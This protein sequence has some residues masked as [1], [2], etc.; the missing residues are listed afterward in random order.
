[1]ID[2]ISPS[3]TGMGL[4]II[5]A[6]SLVN[7]LIDNN[8]N[9]RVWT[10]HPYLFDEIKATVIPLQEGIEPITPDFSEIN[11]GAVWIPHEG[12][13][14]PYICK[15][16]LK[17]SNLKNFEIL[18]DTKLNFATP[19]ALPAYVE[20]SARIL[21]KKFTNIEEKS[22]RNECNSKKIVINL[23][24]AHGT[25]KGLTNFNYVSNILNT[26]AENFPSLDFYFF[27]NA[28]VC[29][30]SRIFFNKS[31]NVKFLIHTESDI[32]IQKAI[33]ESILIISVEGGLIHYSQA[34]KKNFFMLTTKAWHEKIAYLYTEEIMNSTFYVKDY[35]YESL[36]SALYELLTDFKHES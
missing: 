31:K 13:N 16:S 32:R 15:T 25:E 9:V 26:I 2:I 3:K 1:M 22:N 5:R 10:F 27:I 33:N 11:H 18:N 19:A 7:M 23:I 8:F 17:I 35:S 21:N 30:G 34:Q 36:V 6:Q 12:Q 20:K 29:K 14:G 28:N 4:E 24:A